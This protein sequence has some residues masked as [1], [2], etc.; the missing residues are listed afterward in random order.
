[1]IPVEQCS[2]ITLR[3]GSGDY[4]L[5]CMDCGAQWVRKSISTDRAA[6]EEANKGVG[7]SLSGKVRVSKD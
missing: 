2:H 3:F 5:I 7:G 1:M 4:Y 6:P